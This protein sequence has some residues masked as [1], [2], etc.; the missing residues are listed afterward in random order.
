M[1]KNTCS[2]CGEKT[3]YNEHPILDKVIC[4]SCNKGLKYVT[5]GRALSDYKL[6]QTDLKQL[7]YRE[8]P[9]PHYKCASPMK[10]FLKN[11]IEDLS[12]NQNLTK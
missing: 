9:N 1:K 5:K 10:L 7:R 4:R 3:G 6:T 12:K 2:I 8:V 11:Q